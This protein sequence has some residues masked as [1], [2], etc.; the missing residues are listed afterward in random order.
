MEH[1]QQQQQQNAAAEETTTRSG[2][3]KDFIAHT[4]MIGNVIAAAASQ[5]NSYEPLPFPNYSLFDEDYGN[6]WSYYEPFFKSK[7][8]LLLVINWPFF[9]LMNERLLIFD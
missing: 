3:I 4:N 9:V 7:S 1:Q 2:G 8:I 6:F 5:K